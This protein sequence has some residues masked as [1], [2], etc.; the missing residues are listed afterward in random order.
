MGVLQGRG[1]LMDVGEDLV[2]WQLRS[3][4]MALPQRAMRSI[5]HHQKRQ[6]ILQRKI[7]DAHDVRMGQ[8]NQ[9]L[10]F[11]QED[12]SLLLC[13]H[14]VADFEGCLAFEVDML[15]QVDGGL[16]TFSQ[17]AK[18]AIVTKLLS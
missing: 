12:R 2:K 3:I 11:L 5:L 4:G 14:H 9:G 8:T 17:Q 6:A 18:Q 1:H 16:T 15:P 13:K 10:R 7:E